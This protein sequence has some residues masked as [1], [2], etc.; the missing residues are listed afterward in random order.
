MTCADTPVFG[1]CTVYNDFPL[2]CEANTSDCGTYDYAN[3]VCHPS[4]GAPSVSPGSVT[5]SSLDGFKA[6]CDGVGPLSG[7]GANDRGCSFSWADNGCDET[8]DYSTDCAVF[9]N[10]EAACVAAGSSDC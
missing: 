5:C 2:V 4:S 8:P 7:N 10:Y 1:D 3:N 9:N 6:V